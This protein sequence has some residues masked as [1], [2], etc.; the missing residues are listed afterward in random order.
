MFGMNCNLY[1]V[2]IVF[3]CDHRD[4]YSI[5]VSWFSM[6]SFESLTRSDYPRKKTCLGPLLSGSVSATPLYKV[7]RKASTLALIG[8]PTPSLLLLPKRMSGVT[9]V[10]FLRRFLP[11]PR[12][13]AKQAG[14]RV[15]PRKLTFSS[16]PS[17]STQ[18]CNLVQWILWRYGTTG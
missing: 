11:T 2:Y 4:Q 9:W 8:V 12:S 7:A 5:S 13:F 17:P 18:S 3:L 14:P 6:F 1:Y 16:G 15:H 10:L